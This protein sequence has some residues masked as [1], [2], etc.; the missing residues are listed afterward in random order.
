MSKKHIYFEKCFTP[1]FHRGDE[2]GISEVKNGEIYAFMYRLTD[3]KMK[4]FGLGKYQ[5]GVLRVIDLEKNIFMTYN[6]EGQFGRLAKVQGKLGGKWHLFKP[7]EMEV[8]LMKVV[9]EW[10]TAYFTERKIRHDL[11]IEQ[12][13]TQRLENEI[14]SL[15][16]SL[17]LRLKRWFSNMFFSFIILVTATGFCACG[18]NT[19]KTTSE[20]PYDVWLMEAMP[21]EGNP[22]DYDSIMINDTIYEK[23][24]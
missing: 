14:E 9:S 24:K 1:S 17:F 6:S 22:E 20:D 4:K 23:D 11:I 21:P 5:W 15:N 16:S 2:I 8:M 10:R 13:K 7:T 3:K 19:P 12:E 18:G